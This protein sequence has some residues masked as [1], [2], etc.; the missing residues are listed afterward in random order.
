MVA[1]DSP[2]GRLGVTICYDL[3]FPEL[4]QRLA[5]EQNADIML[6]PSAFTKVTGGQIILPP[7]IIRCVCCCCLLLLSEPDCWPVNVRA[8]IQGT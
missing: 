1:C 4:Y 5:F 8:C 6:V 7:P 3:R 2:V